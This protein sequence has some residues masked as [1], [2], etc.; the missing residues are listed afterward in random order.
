[1]ISP[2]VFA[3]NNVQP[4]KQRWVRFVGTTVIPMRM[5]LLVF[6]GR[7]VMHGQEVTLKT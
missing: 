6:V 4:H 5:M 7:D 3:G 1:M 2:R